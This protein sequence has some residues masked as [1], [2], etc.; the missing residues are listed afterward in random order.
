MDRE[1][2]SEERTGDRSSRRGGRQWR[3]EERVDPTNDDVKEVKSELTVD[4]SRQWGLN[5]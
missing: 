3:V 5:R 1:L 4:E 2:Y